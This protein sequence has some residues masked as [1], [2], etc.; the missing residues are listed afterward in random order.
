MSDT[1]HPDDEPS[2]EYEVGYGKPP[3]HSQFQKGQSGNP[4]GRKKGTRGLKTILGEEIGTRYTTR[5]NGE[6]TTGT[7]QELMFRALATRAAH[8]DI[9]AAAILIP[10]LINLFGPEDLGL[11]GRRLSAQD[12]ALLEA[13]LSG[14]TP[15]AGKSDGPSDAGDVP[16]HPDA[17][18]PGDEDGSTRT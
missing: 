1:C 4:R 18:A 17:S 8:G 3:R 9:K 7:K 13:M 5:I 2:R 11:S 12:Q 16:D 14:R 15:E 10:L 6:P